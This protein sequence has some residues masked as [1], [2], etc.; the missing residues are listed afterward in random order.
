MTTAEQVASHPAELVST[1]TTFTGPRFLPWVTLFNISRI[2]GM[3]ATAV[4]LLAVNYEVF[5]RSVMNQPTSWVTEYSA[6]L[7]VAITFLAAAFAQS[8]GAHVRVNVLTDLLNGSASI[9][10][11]SAVSWVGLALMMI[12]T[13]K[14][15]EFVYNEQVADTRNWSILSTPMWVPM[16]V[17]AV[18]YFGLMAA[19]LEDVRRYVS[20]EIS[21]T[22]DWAGRIIIV[23][24]F[25]TLCLDA[26]SVPGVKIST[27]QGATLVAGATLLTSV[28]WGGASTAIRYFVYSLVPVGVY[29]VVQDA[30]LVW[31]GLALILV[32]I[33]FL[34]T[35]FQVT[36]ALTG[37]GFLGLILWMPKPV[38][39]PLAVRAWE[40]IHFFEF[41]AIPTFVFMGCVL[42]R[43]DAAQ[44]LFTALLTLFGR[45][46][47]SLA[48]STIGASGI[49]AAVSG[50]SVASAATLGRV[51]GPQLTSHGYTPS[52]AYGLIAAGGTLGILIPPSV[53]MIVYGSLA[54]VPVTKLFLAGMVP[55][56]LVMIMFA[57]AILVWMAVS[58]KS[59]PSGQPYTVKEKVAS[60]TG[61]LPFIALIVCVL[62]SLYT[63][64][65]T[66]TE[67]GAVGSVGALIVATWRR[68]LSL[69]ILMRALEETALTTSF[70]LMIAVGA[71]QMSY[72]LDAQGMAT[73]LV[74]YLGH[75]NLSH[76]MLM[77]GIV[78]AYLLLGMFIEPISMML[79]T[80][81]VVLPLV[82]AVGWDPL[83]FGVVLVILVEIG[84]ITPPVGMLLF[85]LQGV[86]E[87][88]VDF[89]QISVGAAPFVAV[90]LS[91]IAI[92][93]WFPEL[94]TWLPGFW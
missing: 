43:T 21:V 27:M 88:K 80:L 7:V 94:V 65:A 48:F 74:D 87:G 23:A 73:S 78:I 16:S 79:L 36:Y 61:V 82:A 59:I 58:P 26:F 85:V 77:V 10:L 3:L 56:V 68:Q 13:W 31:Q 40:S 44:R 54:G 18:G 17:V 50:S 51:A 22:K 42:A 89:K 24:L 34:G 15:T 63:G 41:A 60:A 93:Y 92:L 66:P 19:L 90:L 75:L 62:G 20:K 76:G 67:A 55:G 53:A 84:L 14:T 2:L 12:L 71:S 91:A 8:R 39:A 38:L 52:L 64:I 25:V 46:R 49:F 5:S 86:A 81:P 28:L 29:F 35:G 83:W 47:G 32:L 72:V 9:K 30:S 45:T 37:I 11:A 70:L 33:Y 1:S 69:S 57:L 6:Y 4:L